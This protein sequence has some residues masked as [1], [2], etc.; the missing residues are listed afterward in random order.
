MRHTL[1]VFSLLF[2]SLT[3]FS[4]TSSTK[5]CWIK[6][7]TELGTIYCKVPCKDIPKPKITKQLKGGDAK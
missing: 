2:L 7:E 4:Q 5:G 1:L 3:G 6:V